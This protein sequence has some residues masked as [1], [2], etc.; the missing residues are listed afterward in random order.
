ML[1][2]CLV[3]HQGAFAGTLV[4]FLVSMWLAVGSTLYPPSAET[5]GVLNSYTPQCGSGNITVDNI[6]HE[7]LMS[8]SDIPHN[9]DRSVLMNTIS[10][11][12]SQ[13]SATETTKG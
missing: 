1:I 3:H 9:E 12:I 5:M 6:I 8:I 7:E 13:F 11:S 10:F 4:G 2:V